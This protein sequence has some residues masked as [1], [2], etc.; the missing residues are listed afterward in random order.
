M[1]L[2]YCTQFG[3]TESRF[4]MV[5]SGFVMAMSVKVAGTVASTSRLYE[6][7][8]QPWQCY[9]VSKYKGK[10]YQ[11]SLSSDSSTVLHII[12]DMCATL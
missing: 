12:N 2:G 7:V 8:E 10:S 3:R 5:P 4:S 11:I 1:T 6:S 9:R